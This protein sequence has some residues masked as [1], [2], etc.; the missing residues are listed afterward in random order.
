MA[1]WRQSW[2]SLSRC[3]SFTTIRPFT[4]SSVWLNPN[5]SG[6]TSWMHTHSLCF[7]PRC[8]LVFI[9]FVFQYPHFLKRDVNRLHVMLQRRKRYKNRTIL[10]YKTL[11]VG[12]I[13]MAEV[14]RYCDVPLS[15]NRKNVDE[16]LTFHLWP[17]TCGSNFG[18]QWNFFI[19]KYL[20]QS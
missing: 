1:W 18:F 8:K 17:N 11:A 6:V 14:A 16:P 7:R 4:S 5:D 15:T 2:S 9:H 13:N 10:G 3:R 19:T 20:F 12:V